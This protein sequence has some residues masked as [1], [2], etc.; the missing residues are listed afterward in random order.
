MHSEE[1]RSLMPTGA[2]KSGVPKSSLGAVEY[3]ERNYA[4]S[5]RLATV[6]RNSLTGETTQRLASAEK[7]ASPDF[8]AWLR[9]KNARGADIYIS[10]NVFRPEARTRLK[11][12]VDKIRH[13]YLDLDKNGDDALT[14]I[15]D[16]LLVPEPSFVIST[17]PQKYQ[18]I[19]KVAD[20]A[21]NAAETLQKAMVAEFGG[22]PAATDSSRVLRLP[23]FQN[24]KYQRDY[25]V[26]AYAGSDQTYSLPD[27][28]LPADDRQSKSRPV[29]ASKNHGRKS[30]EITQSERDW[31][32]VTQ[33]LR[34]G[35]APERLVE[36]L[37]HFRQDK[38]SPD[39]YARQTVSR[40]YASV[41][42]GRGDKPIEIEQ[43]I[44]QLAT[45]QPHPATYA[46]QT[47]AE[48]KSAK[49]RVAIETEQPGGRSRVP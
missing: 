11:S 21:P 5:D 43:K 25:P 31:A 1:K 28:R 6:V 24:K 40:A 46:R 30:A 17:S 48:M 34:R 18:V 45:H 49:Q 23:G 13:V 35:E 20:M 39:Y 8:Q 27:F 33:Q 37:A 7:I 38:S 2:S 41:A 4:P 16:S 26:E 36:A 42:L 12:D 14:K 19:W 15:G 9:H 22:D 44:A 10:Q 29:E 47:I 32:Y 3:I